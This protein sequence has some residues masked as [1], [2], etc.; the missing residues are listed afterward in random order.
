MATFKALGLLVLGPVWLWPYAVSVSA[1]LRTVQVKK[2]RF[3]LKE[4]SS[5]TFSEI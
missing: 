3:A 5:T 4:L 1:S 2:V